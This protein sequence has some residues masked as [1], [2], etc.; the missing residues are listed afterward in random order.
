MACRGSWSAYW[1]RVPKG[2]ATVHGLRQ[3]SPVGSVY[4]EC[5]RQLD[6]WRRQYADRPNQEIVRLFLLALEREEIVSVAYR[7]ALIVRRLRAMPIAPEPGELI[8]HALIWAW[9]DE[10][11]HAIYL[12]GAI[13][14]LGSRSLRARAYLRQVAGA[15]AGWSQLRAAA[16]PLARRRP[17]ARALAAAARRAGTLTGQ[18]PRDVR[19]TCD[20]RPLSRL[21]P[22]QRRCRAD[23]PAL[24]RPHARAGRPS[25]AEPSPDARRRPPARPRR[26]GPPRPDL[27]HPGRGRSTTEDRLA[28]GVTPDDSPSG[29]ARSAKTSC[30]ATRRPSLPRRTRSA[31]GGRVW[32][33]RGTIRRAR[34]GHSFAGCSTSRAWTIG[35]ASARSAL[36]KPAGTCGWR[37]SRPSCSVTTAKDRSPILTDP[38]LLQDLADHLRALGCPDVAV[39]EAPNIYDRFY[40]DRSVARRGPLLRHRLAELSSPGRSLRG[41]GPARLSA[42]AGAGDGRADLEGGRLPH[43]VRQDA[44]PP[45]RD[46]GYLSVGERR[47]DRRSLRRVPLPGAPGPSRDRHR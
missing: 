10:E 15:V 35:S 42:G 2:T 45:G 6:R 12:R 23:R 11:M 8:R 3:E 25:C 46:G 47:M 20:Y 21:L 28:P 4:D 22:V 24:L 29:S 5:V 37:S 16:R 36:G 43:L 7:E 27:H 26:R 30:P 31:A 14:R 38:D 9:K 39:V 33:V 13:L 40:A 18:V 44:E 17:S 1:L 19:S 41:A 32:V 34:S